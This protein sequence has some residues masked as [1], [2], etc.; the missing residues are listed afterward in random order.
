[1][2]IAVDIGN[3][4][5]KIGFFVNEDLIVK[6][7]PASPVLKN[8]EYEDLING[9]IKE[10]NINKNPEGSII[11]S[12]VSEITEILFETM[13]KI[14]LSEPVLV[15][16]KIDT[17]ITF[18]I[19]KP[20]ELGADRIANIVAANE[21]YKSPVCVIDFGTATTLSIKG[22]NRDFIGGAILPGIKMM[23]ESLFMKTSKLPDINIEKPDR[24]LGTDTE[25]CIKSGIIY[26]TAGAIERILDEIE[27]D[28]NMN[29]EL[30]LTGGFCHLISGYLN[31]KYN[32][33]PYLTINGLKIL[34]MR[35]C[36][37]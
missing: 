21:L 34:Y 19:P 27:K 4:S 29:F 31:R 5:I 33:I 6:N 14:S 9:F 13:K 11:C 37:A 17:G 20:E 24:A 23:K 2:I 36:H 16:H 18:S 25:N 15:N 35:N 22:R 26:G 1:M 3:T 8:T 32:I 7:I 10:I 28:T 12:V 30:V